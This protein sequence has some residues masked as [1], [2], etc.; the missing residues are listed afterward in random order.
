MKNF[1]Q[2][3]K[4]FK[5]AKLS[6]LNLRKGEVNTPIFMP[7][8]TKGS[9]KGKIYYIK[10]KILIYFQIR[11]NFYIYVYFCDI[12]FLFIISIFNIQNKKNHIKT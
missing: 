3:H 11:F 9:I 2:I 8:G 10:K 5:K 6:T 1:F 7:V 12:Y 4:K